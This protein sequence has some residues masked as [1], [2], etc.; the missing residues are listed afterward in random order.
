[1]APAGLVEL[2]QGDS[3]GLTA[4]LSG[5][6]HFLVGRVNGL[7]QHDSAFPGVG[8]VAAPADASLDLPERPGGVRPWRR[9][10]PHL[11]LGAFVSARCVVLL[12]GN[13]LA[14]VAAIVSAAAADR[15]G[16]GV[17]AE[18]PDPPG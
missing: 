10:S 6:F 1:M 2:P 3:L 12:S 8:P 13:L 9:Q 4:R 14:E 18:A 16:R 7:F 17:T 5:L 15:R 11:H